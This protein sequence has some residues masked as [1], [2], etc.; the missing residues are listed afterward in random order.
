MENEIMKN[1]NGMRN[2]FSEIKKR[3]KLL[4]KGLDDLNE[5]N[6]NLK[7]ELDFYKQLFIS[8]PNSAVFNLYGKTKKGKKVWVDPIRDSREYLE[9]L[10]PDDEINEWLEPVKCEK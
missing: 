10:D 5:E 4:E 1:I 6:E 7:N 3:M 2:N 9:S 8:H